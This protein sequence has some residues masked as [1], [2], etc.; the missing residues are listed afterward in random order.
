MY[1]VKYT[2]GNLANEDYCAKRKMKLAVYW[3]SCQESGNS[4]A[5]ICFASHKDWNINFKI[6]I[7]S[8]CSITYEKIFLTLNKKR[9]KM[10]KIVKMFIK[11]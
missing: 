11:I 10:S 7:Y 6:N 9:R 1:T 4:T 2:R 8:D 3:Q 5:A